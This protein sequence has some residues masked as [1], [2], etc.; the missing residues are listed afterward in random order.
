M[1]GDEVA[2]REK[3]E[4][5]SARLTHEDTA[6]REVEVIAADACSRRVRIRDGEESR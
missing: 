2:P 4:F 3:L 5:L 6:D 1:P